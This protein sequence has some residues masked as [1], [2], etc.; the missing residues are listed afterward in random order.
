MVAHEAHILLKVGILQGVTLGLVPSLAQAFTLS[1]ALFNIFSGTAALPP[2]PT[3]TQT[4]VQ[5]FHVS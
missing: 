2:A 5:M 4:Q 3:F 1:L